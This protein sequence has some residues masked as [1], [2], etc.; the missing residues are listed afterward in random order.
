MNSQFQNGDL[1]SLYGLDL[2][3][4]RMIHQRSSNLLYE[5]LHRAP[6]VRFGC[7]TT[8][9]DPPPVRQRARHFTPPL[10]PEPEESERG[11]ERLFAYAIFCCLMKLRTVSLGCAPTPSQYLMRSESNLISAG[12]FSGSYVPTASRTR[13]SR[14]RVLSI[15][16]T[17]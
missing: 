13:P 4:L 1:R 12:F 17:R 8:S 14:A 15:T 3:S 16:T 9:R 5:F 7:Q 2:H 10:G 6:R 11:L